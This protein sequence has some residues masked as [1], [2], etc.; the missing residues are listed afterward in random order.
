MRTGRWLQSAKLL[1]YGVAIGA[2]YGLAMRLIV[3]FG[4]HSNILA[5]V[6]VAFVFLTPF[7]MGFLSVFL[8]ERRQGET[9]WFWLALSTLPVVGA[10]IGTMVM[11]LEG[12]ICVVM[13]APVGLTCSILGGLLGGVVA[14][15]S[16][17]I[18]I[19]CI[20]L[21]PLAVNPWE[22][23]VLLKSETRTVETSIDIR[24][25]S[26][27]VWQNIKTVPMISA[28][29]ISPS[30]TSKL[31]FPRPLEAT[32]SK[33]GIGGVRHARFEGGVLFIETVDVWERERDLAFTIKAQTAQIPA[34]TL[35][36]HVT[37]GGP[38]FDTLR[39]EY[40]LET[41]PGGLTRLHL[42]S[43][44]RLSTDFNW[45][46]HLWTDAVMADIQNSILGV[47]RNRCEAQQK[48]LAASAN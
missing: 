48:R 21:L 25:N 29:E 30:W 5:V 40:V 36:P 32:L 10:L 11:E 33:E 39:G 24:A 23:K 35:D 43:K 17:R 2:G 15:H 45:Y 7:C 47:I 44:H 38:F 6:S 18:S 12:W 46:S 34:T 8:V 1:G 9:V 3:D 20:V 13:F 22:A 19:T 28:S 27:I 16:R 14:R 41:L 26:M 31:G 37:V 42:S 4:P